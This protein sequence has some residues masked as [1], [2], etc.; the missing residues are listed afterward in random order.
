[1]KKLMALLMTLVLLT[2]CTGKREE[3]DR[4]MGLRAELLGSEGCSF[5]A[6]LTADYGDEVHEFTLY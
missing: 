3:M 4:V 2:G 5:T 6:H 1:M